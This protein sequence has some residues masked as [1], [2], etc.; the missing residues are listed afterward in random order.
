MRGRRGGDEAL[1]MAI[2]AKKA[3]TGVVRKCLSL[4]S[5]TD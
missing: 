3:V 5:S 4:A 1:V 2:V